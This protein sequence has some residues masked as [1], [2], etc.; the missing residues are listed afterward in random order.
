ML[1]TVF[2]LKLALGRL[3]NAIHALSWDEKY[4]A[5]GGLVTLIT[6]LAMYTHVYVSWCH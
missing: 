6:E 3:L 2:L 4:R 1:K 5:D